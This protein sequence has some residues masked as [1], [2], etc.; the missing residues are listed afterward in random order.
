MFRPTT[1]RVP[2]NGSSSFDVTPARPA[3]LLSPPETELE[4][5]HLQLNPANEGVGQDPLPTETPANRFRRVAY[6]TS[7]SL[8]TR[9][10]D[11]QRPPQRQSKW[12]IMV[13]PPSSLNE[14]P[15]LG[16]TLSS[17]PAGR[18]SHGI[19]MPLFSTVSLLFQRH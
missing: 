2:F 18:F 15:V 10:R 1:G 3:P 4:Q 6:N 14:P 5:A 8:L 13:A 9:E 12:L 11:Q 16:H 19:L 17:A 7:G